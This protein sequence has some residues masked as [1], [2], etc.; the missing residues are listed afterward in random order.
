MPAPPHSCPALF[1]NQ[2]H[3]SSP[4]PSTAKLMHP[5]GTS[6]ASCIPSPWAQGKPDEGGREF[7][8]QAAQHEAY[9]LGPVPLC[10]GWG[11]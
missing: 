11:P 5:W 8:I 10:L 3:P 6:W 7:A 9:S 2:H 1:C 4:L